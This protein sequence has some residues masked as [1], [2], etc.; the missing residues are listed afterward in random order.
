MIPLARIDLLGEVGR[1][2]PEVTRRTTTRSGDHPEAR[3]EGA[4]ND[5]RGA[6][7]PDGD[8]L[9]V[10]DYFPIVEDLNYYGEVV[11][12]AFH[13][14]V[15]NSH[16]DRSRNSSPLLGD[17]GPL[18]IGNGRPEADCLAGNSLPWAGIYYPGNNDPPRVSSN[19]HVDDDP[20][21]KAAR[22][23]DSE[24][25]DDHDHPVEDDCGGARF[26]I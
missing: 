7:G 2:L 23:P 21:I 10:V 1:F 11:D 8:Y 25:V 9:V 4:A 3:C 14:L 24:M 18:Y 6:M 19:L 17:R 16:P 5:D 26:G 20:R 13:I 22:H 12:R 15:C